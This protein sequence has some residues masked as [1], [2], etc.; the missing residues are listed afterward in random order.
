[1]TK[2][3]KKQ[4]IHLR[5]IILI[6]LVGIIFG[7]IYFSCDFLYN[8]LTVLLT[9]IKLGP[10]AN[11]IV[12]GIWCMAG[13]VAGFLVPHVGSGF[14]GEF[15]GAAGEA[16]LGGE[17]GASNLISGCVQGIAAELGFTFTGYKLYNW[18]TTIVTV[19]TMTVITFAWDW[20]RNGYAKFTPTMQIT[21]FIIRLVSMF[22]FS[23]VLVQLIVKLLRRAH[24]VRKQA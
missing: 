12:I 2:S 10:A 15:L 21:C 5:D 24:V 9:P 6:A 14:L 19:I 8:A 11:D 13:P 1:M 16:V 22:I 3:T 17:W 4:P 23:G 20:F 7:V 18:V